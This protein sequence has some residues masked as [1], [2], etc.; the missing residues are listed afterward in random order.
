MSHGRVEAPLS[1][2][3][4]VGAKIKIDAL[5][6]GMRVFRLYLL[7]EREFQHKIYRKNDQLSPLSNNM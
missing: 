1:P 4:G 7:N 5:I 6:K 2:A 3:I